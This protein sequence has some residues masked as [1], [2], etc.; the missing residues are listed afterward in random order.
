MRERGMYQLQCMK[1]RSSTGVGQ[2]I[3]LEYNVETMRITDNGNNNTPSNTVQPTSKM[4]RIIRTDTTEATE[5]E[6][7]QVDGPRVI[8]NVQST[9]LKAMLN[10]I[11]KA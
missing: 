3:D 9:K 2:K 4:N 11:K 6:G 8:A 1:S 7:S 5:T 10:S